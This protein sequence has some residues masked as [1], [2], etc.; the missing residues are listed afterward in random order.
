MKCGKPCSHRISLQCN[1]TKPDF[2]RAL[3]HLPCEGESH[4]LGTH[5][6]RALRARTVGAA[7][8][9]PASSEAPQ[10]QGVFT[11]AGH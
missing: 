1:T 11:Q 2:R 4:L 8:E 5:T 7:S 6:A 3:P 9:V 10:G